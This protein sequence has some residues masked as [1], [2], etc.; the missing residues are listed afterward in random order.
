MGMTR[1]YIRR[2]KF[3]LV[4][5][6][7][8]SKK[9]KD[10]LLSSFTTWNR[11]NL[12][13]WFKRNKIVGAKEA[14]K[15]SKWKNNLVR[16]YLLGIDLLIFKGWINWNTGSAG[17][18]IDKNIKKEKMKEESKYDYEVVATDVVRK[19]VVYKGMSEADMIIE[20]YKST[21]IKFNN[22]KSKYLMNVD[23]DFLSNCISEINELM[24][25][26]VKSR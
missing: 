16:D 7:R 17:L 12:G 8:Y 3:V 26:G 9:E 15:P 23:E 25:Y 10:D 2:T 19:E 13:L 1:F 24:N 21:S 18:V 22:K 20:I 5:K 14:N 4:W 6:Y 11:W